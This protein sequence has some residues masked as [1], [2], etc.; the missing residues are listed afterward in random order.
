ML[1]VFLLAVVLAVVSLKL[2]QD[3]RYQGAVASLDRLGMRHRVGSDGL[4]LE[5]RE[6]RLSDESVHELI[7][8][9]QALQ[10]P[11]DLGLSPGLTITLIDLNGANLSDE[12]LARL[13]QALPATRIEK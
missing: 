10:S 9:L 3:A 5:C 7:E 6:P 8:Q 11:H 1:V 4:R 2:R 13:R 12:S